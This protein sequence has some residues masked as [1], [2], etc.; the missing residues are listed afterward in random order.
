MRGSKGVRH[1]AREFG[2][3]ARNARTP[4]HHIKAATGNIRH[5]VQALE[6]MGLVVKNKKYGG[7]KISARG[8]RDLD[9]IATRLAGATKLT[10]KAKAT[11]KA[12]AI[13][14]AAANAAAAAA[15]PAAAA[16]QPAAA[17]ATPAAAAATPAASV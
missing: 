2:T 9:R 4:R 14:L 6:A 15:Q 8:R 11:A 16:A 7:R 10:K 1:L 17:A 12:A 5:A 13:T 3:A